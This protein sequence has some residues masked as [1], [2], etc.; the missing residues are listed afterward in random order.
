MVPITTANGQV[1]QQFIWIQ[2]QLVRADGTAVSDWIDE[3]GTIST[4]E[5]ATMR[6]TGDLIRNHLY[7]ATAP[8]NQYLYVAE[9][10]HGILSQLPKG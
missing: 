3:M 5:P 2:I 7:F 6:L 8:G 4:A 9:T 1:Y 10:A